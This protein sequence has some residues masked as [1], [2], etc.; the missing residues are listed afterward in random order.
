MTTGAMNAMRF[1]VGIILWASVFIVPATAWSALPL[2]TDDTE[3]QGKGRFQVEIGGEYDRDRGIVEGVLIKEMDYAVTTTLTYGIVDHGDVFIILPYQWLR[4]KN[5]GVMVANTDGVSDIAVG[6]K[7]RLYEERGLSFA[8]KPGASIPT[9]SSARGL[10]TGKAD[11][12]TYLIISKES[13]PWEV[14]MNLGY[15]RNEN[16]IGE[17]RD[18]WHAS[19]AGA[20]EV[21]KLLKICADIGIE[22]NRDKT[23]E[24][25]PSYLLGGIIYSVKENFELSLGVKVGLSNP[26]TDYAVLPGVTYRF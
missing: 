11:Y 8:V 2:I 23:S 25:E 1:F 14:H 7:W 24:V 22:T 20:Y 19:L 15:I 4:V 9:G 26:G 10:G 21:E 16:R 12:N 13:D 6:V 5:D 17:R 3:T 18:I